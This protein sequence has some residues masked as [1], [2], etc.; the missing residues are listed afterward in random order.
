MGYLL[1][2]CLF[3]LFAKKIVT[4]L[5]MSKT[6]FKSLKKISKTF[7]L[8]VLNSVPELQWIQTSVPVC[9]L[10]LLWQMNQSNLIPFM[11]T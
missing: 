6:L 1:P 8:K 10:V 9:N 4:L 2:F 3:I 5:V 7:N 11:I